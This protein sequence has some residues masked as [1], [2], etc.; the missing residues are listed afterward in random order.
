MQNK[1]K[2]N[3]KHILF[4]SALSAFLLTAGIAY[5]IAALNVTLPLFPAIGQATAQPC[6]NDGVNT[7]FTYG[8]SSANGVRVTSA[9]ISGISAFCTTATIEFLAS[10]GNVVEAKTGSVSNGTATLNVNVWTNDFVNVRVILA[11]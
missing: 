6:D 11:P 2:G 4:L 3:R 7:S 5:G 9:T 1:Q 10:S 8:N